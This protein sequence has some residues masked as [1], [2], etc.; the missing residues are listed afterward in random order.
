MNYWR[1]RFGCLSEAHE[2][3]VARIKNDNVSVIPEIKYCY[4][5]DILKNRKRQASLTVNVVLW[6]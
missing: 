1:N 2:V 3:Q 5:T 6:N 4:T